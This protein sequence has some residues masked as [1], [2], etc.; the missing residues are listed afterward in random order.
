MS[1][2]QRL[3]NS[4]GRGRSCTWRELYICRVCVVQLGAYASWELSARPTPGTLLLLLDSAAPAAPAARYARAA[5]AARHARAAPAAGTLPLQLRKPD[6]LHD[7]EDHPTM[8]TDG[9]RKPSSLVR[10]LSTIRLPFRYMHRP[11]SSAADDDTPGGPPHVR[12]QH[13]VGAQRSV[14]V[15]PVAQAPQ[16]P[17]T[18]TNDAHNLHLDKAFGVDALLQLP[19]FPHTTQDAKDLLAIACSIVEQRR[20]R[21]LECVA[22]VQSLSIETSLWQKQL[23]RADEELHQAQSKIDVVRAAIR[24]SGFPI[25]FA[26]PR[27]FEESS[28][29]EI[30]SKYNDEESIGS[31]E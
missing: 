28:V 2:W 14:I 11:S 5:P 20:I 30:G 9:R 25:G 17:P 1:S 23:Q 4:L 29:D 27:Q 15:Q 16:P 19:G 22:A 6:G 24:R 12:E 3:Y 8:S 7:I 31:D 18:V 13:S 10:T 26:P 21:R